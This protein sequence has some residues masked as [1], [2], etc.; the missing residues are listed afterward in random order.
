MLKKSS[1]T[2]KVEVQVKAEKKVSDLRSTL[3]STS[4]C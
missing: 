3:T 1:S 4:A 2:E